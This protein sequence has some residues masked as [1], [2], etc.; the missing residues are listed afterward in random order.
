MKGDG[1]SVPLLHEAVTLLLQFL[2]LTIAPIPV[3]SIQIEN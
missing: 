2:Y 3:I 1:V